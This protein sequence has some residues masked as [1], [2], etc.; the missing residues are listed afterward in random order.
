MAI[1]IFADGQILLNG[2][3]HANRALFIIDIPFKLDT[4]SFNL[5]K[6]WRI[7]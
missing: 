6:Y 1:G 7:W 2:T 4:D 5:L 3:H